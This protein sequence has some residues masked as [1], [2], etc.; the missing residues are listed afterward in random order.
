[1][2]PGL[3]PYHSDSCKEAAEKKTEKKT[4]PLEFQTLKKK[5]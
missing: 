1:M 2:I 3:N 4:S 5:I